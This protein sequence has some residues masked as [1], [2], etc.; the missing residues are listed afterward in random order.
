[1]NRLCPKC[2]QRDDGQTPDTLWPLGWTCPSCAHMV[3]QEDGTVLL[4][5]ELADGGQGFESES[6]AQLAE[7]EAGHFWFEHRNTLITWLMKKYFPAPPSILEIGCG[8]GYVLRHVAETFPQAHITGSELHPSGLLFAKQRLGARAQF[9]QCDARHLR[10]SNAVGLIGA[11]DVLE[12]IA[13]DVGVLRSMHSAL[14]EGGGVVI[15]VPQH[16]FLWSEYDEYGKHERR[17]MRGEMEQKLDSTGFEVLHSTSY[18]SL[19][20]PAMAL[21][22]VLSDLR[23]KSQSGAPEDLGAEFKPSPLINAVFG[24]ITKLEVML[25]R[26]G[27]KW[28]L[29]GSRVIVARKRKAS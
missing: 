27:V 12:H 3:Q 8:T 14:M 28:P 7:V 24:A 25:T 4:N 5:P 10:L 29:G 17:Y 6:H 13:D 16:P 18:I 26:L 23:R 1:M 15:T 22:R 20:L 11:Y 9:F 21:S 2:D 19:L